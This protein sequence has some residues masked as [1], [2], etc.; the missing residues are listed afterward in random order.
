MRDE[1]GAAGGLDKLFKVSE[2][3]VLVVCVNMLG[4][5]VE[6]KIDAHLGSSVPHNALK[7]PA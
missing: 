2:K 3:I 4:G 7:L 1:D 5:L 6:V